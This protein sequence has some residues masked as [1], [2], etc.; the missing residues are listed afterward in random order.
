MDALPA[1]AFR[2]KPTLL[3]KEYRKAGLV[4]TGFWRGPDRVEALA[5]QNRDDCKTRRS[6]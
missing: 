3:Y 4:S 5:G 2:K 1:Y 6:Q